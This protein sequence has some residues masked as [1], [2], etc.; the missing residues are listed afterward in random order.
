MLRMLE[1]MR[2]ISAFTS[3]S[4]TFVLG[5]VM[6]YSPVY[7]DASGLYDA[8]LAGCIVVGVNLVIVRISAENFGHTGTLAQSDLHQQPAA[9]FEQLRCR[10]NQF[11]DDLHAK[12]SAIE[13]EA[14][15]VLADFRRHPVHARAGYVGRVAGDHVHDTLQVLFAEWLKQITTTEPDILTTEECGILA[16]KADGLR[17]EIG[18]HHPRLRQMAGDAECNV[19]GASADIDDE[20]PGDGQGLQAVHG[21][22]SKLLGF[23]ARYECGR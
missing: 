2:S 14:G 8:D 3:S 5:F 1:L 20:W 10:G 17:A 21:A 7:R 13:G 9:R 15:F 18:A 11:A 23:P 22:V 19:A 6:F 16:G 12:W 4:R